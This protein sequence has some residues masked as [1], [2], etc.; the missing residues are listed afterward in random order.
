MDDRISLAAGQVLLRLPSSPA[1]TCGT[2]P[3]RRVLLLGSQYA[4]TPIAPKSPDVPTTDFVMNIRFFQSEQ[5]KRLLVMVV[6]G[7]F[8]T[9]VP[10]NHL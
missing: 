2:L 10:K 5:S 9:I 8:P 7:N 1:S 3:S 4:I 6:L